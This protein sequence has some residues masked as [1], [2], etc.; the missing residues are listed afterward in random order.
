MNEEVKEVLYK[1]LTLTFVEYKSGKKN[2][3][4][5][6]FKLV[7]VR[8]IDF[9]FLQGDLLGFLLAWVSMIPLFFAIS[10]CTLI[11]IRR[12]LTTVYKLFKQVTFRVTTGTIS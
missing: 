10:I 7:F 6:I 8:K 11:V 12:D 5:L 3:V 4:F 1:P 9:S 2:N